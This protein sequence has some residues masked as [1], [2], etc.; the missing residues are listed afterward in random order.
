MVLLLLILS[1]SLFM[2][3][4]LLVFLSIR[5]RLYRVDGVSAQVCLHQS[6]DSKGEAESELWNG[7]ESVRFLVFVNRQH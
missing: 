7:K 5:S 6:L 2:F 1:I 3:I 4:V